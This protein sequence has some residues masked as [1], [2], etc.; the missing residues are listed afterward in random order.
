MIKNETKQKVLKYDTDMNHKIYENAYY[1]L[2]KNYKL[3][4]FFSF[5]LFRIIIIIFKLLVLCKTIFVIIFYSNKAD[6]AFLTIAKTLL[7]IL[8]NIKRINVKNI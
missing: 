5:C 1:N 7:S 4:K 6:F 8:H 2:N 3:F